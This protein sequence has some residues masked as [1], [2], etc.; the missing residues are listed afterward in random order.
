[1]AGGGDRQGVAL[2]LASLGGVAGDQGLA[3]TARALHEESLALRRASADRR[4]VAQSLNNLGML[5]FARGDYPQRRRAAGGELW[6]CTGELRDTGGVASA[7]LMLGQTAG[8]QGDLRQA[9]RLCSESLDLFR[10]VGNL[11]GDR[12]GPAGHRA[13]RCSTRA[14]GPRAEELLQA[15]LDERPRT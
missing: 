6:P 14:T 11:L 3:E 13:G 2:A 5:A 9:T 10:E 7:L 1:M 12:H 15:S 8:R 4:G